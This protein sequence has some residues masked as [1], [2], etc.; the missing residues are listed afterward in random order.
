MVNFVKIKEDINS[1]YE[2]VSFG[3]DGRTG[4]NIGIIEDEIGTKY[5]WVFW[6]TKTSNDTS[7]SYVSL[8]PSKNL[9]EASV[10]KETDWDIICKNIKEL[11]D[12]YR[13]SLTRE[14]IKASGL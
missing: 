4:I 12:N 3:Y 10:P 8:V 6:I 9:E 14:I 5:T 11:N 2:T 7:K 1:E 13:N